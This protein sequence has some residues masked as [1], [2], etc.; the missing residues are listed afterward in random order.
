MT[1]RLYYR[2]SLVLDQSIKR[3]KV[4]LDETCHSVDLEGNDC[5]LPIQTYQLPI[6]F[7]LTRRTYI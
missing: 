5:N 2:S 4:K 1:I 3:R 6:S 7:P